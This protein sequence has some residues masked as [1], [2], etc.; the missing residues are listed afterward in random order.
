MEAD[1]ARSDG[2]AEGVVE[3]QHQREAAQQ[4]D[5]RGALVPAAVSPVSVSAFS[6]A[7]VYSLEQSLGWSPRP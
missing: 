5:R 1:A 4:G 6:S 2:S 3:R 7:A